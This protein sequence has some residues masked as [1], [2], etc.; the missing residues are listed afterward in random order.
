[1]RL[2]PD[3]AVDHVRAGFLEPPR[4]LD[5]VRLVETRAQ[6]DQR[7]HLFAGVGGIDQRL[8]DRRIAAR[9]IE[10][11]LDREHLR[12]GRRALDQLHHRVVTFVGMMEQNILPPHRLED[13][14]VRRQRRIARRLEDAVL[15]FREGVVRDQRREVR[16][17]ERAVELVKIGLARAGRNRGANRRSR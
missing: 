5:V 16:H 10:R 15:Q 12:I 2:Q 11:D 17:R 14:R 8:D 1:M 13:I 9:A 4:P 7:R 3:H 6:F